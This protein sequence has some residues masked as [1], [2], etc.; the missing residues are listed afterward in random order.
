MRKR[1]LYKDFLSRVPL[2]ANLDQ[3]ELLKIADAMSV[4]YYEAGAKVITQGEPGERFYIIIEGKVT[5]LR[6]DVETYNSPLE[7][8]QYFGELALL[9]NEPRAATCVAR[10]HL[11][12]KSSRAL[13]GIC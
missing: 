10:K 12:A 4:D 2:L 8:G 6:D 7:A 5:V 13:F 11:K 3:Y 9:S 1:N